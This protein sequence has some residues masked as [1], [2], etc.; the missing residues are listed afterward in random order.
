MGNK[1]IK[2]DEYWKKVEEFVEEARNATEEVSSEF[3]IWKEDSAEWL[4]LVYSPK[5]KTVRWESN[6]STFIDA[7]FDVN[8]PDDIPEVIRDDDWCNNPKS[9]R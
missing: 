2:I 1:M 3:L 6:G 5:D 8:S 7:K 4:Y 9:S